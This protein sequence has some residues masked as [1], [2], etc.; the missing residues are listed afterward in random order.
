MALQIV[1]QLHCDF[2]GKSQHEAEIL[3]SGHNNICICDACVVLS[4]EIVEE[5]RAKRASE[6]ESQ[7]RKTV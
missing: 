6:A 3:I 2:C 4:L 1:S 7:E 5:H